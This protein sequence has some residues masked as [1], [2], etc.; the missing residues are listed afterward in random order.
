MIGSR[1]KCLRIKNGLSQQELC[2]EK[3]NRTI[4]SH[5][6]NNKML[7]SLEQLNY[8]SDELGVNICYFLTEDNNNNCCNEVLISTYHDLYIRNEFIKIIQT[9]SEEI[10]RHNYKE[11]I[12][13]LFYVGMSYFNINAKGDSLK[14]LR[15]F[16]YRY[17]K[18]SYDN[19][20]ELALQAVICLNTLFKLMLQNNN[21]EKGIKYLSIAK[22]Y[23]Y[24]FDI[25]DTE[26]SYI[27]HSNLA[28]A[29]FLIGKY[30][31]VIQ[32]LES[33]IKYNK[34]HIYS[35]IIPDIHLSLSLA[36]YNLEEYS[37]AIENINR[38]SFFCTY[39]GKADFA[40]LNNLNLINVYRF[41]GE[42]ERAFS[43]VEDCKSKCIDNTETYLR[44]II[45]E[46]ILFFNTN[47]FDKAYDVLT[48]IPFN[49]LSINNKHE[50]MLIKAHIAFLNKD[51]KSAMNFYKK[52]KNYFYKNNYNYDLSLIYT[53]LFYI[54]SDE[55][56]LEL[57]M[58][59]KSM[60]Y[61]KN[62][63]TKFYMP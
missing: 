32:L 9:Y 45:Q 3:L 21:Y 5:I 41:C 14:Y 61:R 15:K 8:I 56:Y 6:E 54:T 17:S 47:R 13:K 34:K 7:P 4:L 28:Y 39:I 23:L 29:Y 18:L 1:V 40:M 53:D 48:S 50:Y 63:V 11:E 51:Y 49:Q 20:K 31:N 37:L 42:F 2:S 57:I 36:Y 25:I 30:S 60:P 26:E 55:T 24:L 38:S 58:N 16:I 52:C 19:Q 62:I 12:L 27:I 59:L 46:A 43:L 33:F 22:K 10:K 44:F 35:E